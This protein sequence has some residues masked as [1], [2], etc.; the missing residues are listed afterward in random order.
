LSSS[1]KVSIKYG[2]LSAEFNVIPSTEGPGGIDI[3]KLMA[4]TGLSSY[5]QGFVNTS[6]TKSTL[7]EKKAFFATADT[8]SSSS[9]NTRLS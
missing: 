3:S 5:D 2:D 1:D 6:S 7:M 4:T 9:Q 8:Q